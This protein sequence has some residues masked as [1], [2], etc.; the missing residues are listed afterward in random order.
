MKRK[1]R[2][3]RLKSLGMVFVAC[4]L[5][6][7]VAGIGAFGTVASNHQASVSVSSPSDAYLGVSVT[8][9][10]VSAN[11]KTTV[12]LGTITNHFTVTLTSVDLTITKGTSGSSLVNNVSVEAVPLIPEESSALTATVNCRAVGKTTETVTLHIKATGSDTHISIT[13]KMQIRCGSPLSGSGGT[14]T[15]SSSNQPT[16]QTSLVAS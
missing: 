4:G 16:G 12:S 8:E 1:G 10:V 15:T 7:T 9:P 11:T 3:S 6:L 14:N 5:V 13:R 2:T